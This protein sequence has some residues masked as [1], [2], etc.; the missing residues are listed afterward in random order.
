MNRPIQ[1]NSKPQWTPLD[2]ADNLDEFRRMRTD[3]IFSHKRLYCKLTCYAFN[4]RNEHKYWGTRAG[5]YETLCP[6]H[7]LA[8]KDNLQ[9][10]IFCSIPLEKSPCSLSPARGIIQSNFDR[11]VWKIN[12]VIYIMYPNCMTDI[13]ILAQALLQIFCPGWFTTQTAKVEKGR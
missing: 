8:P 3:T 6:Q 10:T 12:Q 1:S 11:I 4:K 2:R 9:M 7:M 5:V 13:M